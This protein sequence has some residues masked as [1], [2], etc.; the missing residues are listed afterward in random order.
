MPPSNAPGGRI[1]A[2]GFIKIQTRSMTYA[3]GFLLEQGLV[4]AADS[5]TNAGVDQVSVARKITIFEKP[6][7][8]F[9][10]LLSSGNL[11]ITQAVIRQLMEDLDSGG[12][13]DLHAVSTMFAAARIVGAALRNVYEVDAEYMAEQG[14]EFNAAF[15]FGGQVNGGEARLFMI[16]S[17]GNFI[18]ASVE[19][20]YLQI[21]ETK[22]GKP[23]IDRTITFGSTIEQA[24]KCA[25]LSF[26]ST[27]RSNVSVGP[28]I[29]ITTYERDS[30]KSGLQVN[31][32]DGD[33]Y[34]GQIREYWGGALRQAF[35]DMPDPDWLKSS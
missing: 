16:Y 4:F 20:P 1:P 23:I 15:I 13:G 7:D 25:L 27:M 26:D 29:D 9:M 24:I 34:L 2:P 5:R 3:V 6:G 17:A 31:L 10:A 30:L 12:T 28:P 21:G 8:R 22:Y 33:P 19:T 11:A 32:E 18:E 14:L 35:Q